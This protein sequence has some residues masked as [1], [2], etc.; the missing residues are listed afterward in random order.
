MLH[1]NTG[2]RKGQKYIGDVLS[3]VIQKQAI[4]LPV[5]T[6]KKAK[7]LHRNL[8]NLVNTTTDA[9]CISQISDKRG[10]LVCPCMFSY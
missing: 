1:W 7:V 6:V 10:R 4:R 3:P 9:C 8:L 5:V 2:R